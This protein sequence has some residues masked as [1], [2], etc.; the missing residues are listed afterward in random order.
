MKKLILTIAIAC[1]SLV[2]AQAQTQ[3]EWYIGTSDISN[4]AWTQV[5]VSPTI[6][7]TVMDNLLVSATVSQ[8]ADDK[9]DVDLSVRYFA[10]GY[11]AFVESDLDLSIEEFQLGVGK[12]F[13]LLDNVYVDP[14][15]I[16]NVNDQTLNLGIGFGLRF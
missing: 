9:M 13:T 6:G 11:F 15:M 7:Y 12:M 10:K 16:Y 14:K 4:V 8:V 3:G 1:A 5:A 2:T